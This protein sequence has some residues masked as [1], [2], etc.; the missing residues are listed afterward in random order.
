MDVC[1]LFR[2]PRELRDQIYVYTL[3]SADGLHYQ[4]CSDGIRRL[5][6]TP[7]TSSIYSSISRWLY[8]FLAHKKRRDFAYENN[9]LKYACKRLHCETKG[10]DLRY[11]L[12]VFED[13]AKEDALEQCMFL[14]YRCP[15]LREVAIKCSLSTFQR[16]YT[17]QRFSTIVRYFE[18]HVNVIARIYVPYWSQADP[19]FIL[20]GLHFLSTLRASTTT[21]AQF[22]RNILVS[23]YPES[24]APHARIPSNIRI[25]PQD[26]VFCRET[27]E[28]SCRKNSVVKMPTEEPELIEILK[29]VEGWFEYGL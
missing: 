22:A 9:Q 23:Y 10:L 20:I 2:L 1:P 13:L 29:R 24:F 26:R 28:Q 7:T 14:L 8:H 11:N 4:T 19:N 12:I 21:I 6:R 25:F 15:T 16:N 3:Y 17:T 27:F 18:I 5:C